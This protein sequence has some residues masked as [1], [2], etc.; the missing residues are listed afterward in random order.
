MV[1]RDKSENSEAATSLN[2]STA[3]I[4]PLNHNNNDNTSTTASN[5][6]INTPPRMAVVEVDNN[7]EDGID[8][9]ALFAKR[10]RHAHV[11]V[12]AYLHACVCMYMHMYV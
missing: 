6:G 4:S 3:S 2:N 7:L 9:S 11:D 8:M 1:Q 12:D 10:G 5:T